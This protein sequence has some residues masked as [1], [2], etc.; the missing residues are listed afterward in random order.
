M[1]MI[2]MYESHTF[3]PVQITGAKKKKL[4][5]EQLEGKIERLAAKRDKLKEMLRTYPTDRV[6]G[7]KP[8]QAELDRT[9][10]TI[11]VVRADLRL[12]REIL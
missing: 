2:P 4:F 11:R 9:V 3:K 1:S 7:R 12:A 5:I 6:W 8:L 10:H